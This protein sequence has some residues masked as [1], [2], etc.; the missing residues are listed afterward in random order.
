MTLGEQRRKALELL[1]PPP[2]RRHECRRD[3]EYALDWVSGPAPEA[4]L[5]HTDENLIRANLSDAERILHVA[6]RKELYEKLHPE[7]KHGGDRRSARARSSS[8]NENLKAF[9]AD[10]AVKTGKGRSTV[11]RGA[12]RQ[13]ER[14]R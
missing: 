5:I 13:D 9:V 4:E 11:A 1:A 10:I 8:Q 12:V 3:I 14:G 6:R 7:T 2:S